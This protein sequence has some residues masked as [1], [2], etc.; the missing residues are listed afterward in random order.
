MPHTELL[1]S[2]LT[3]FTEKYIFPDKAATAAED[4]RA[5]MATGEFDDLDEETLS[6]R[7]TGLLD[8]HCGDKHLRLRPSEST[9]TRA[10]AASR[11]DV[12][13]SWNARCVRTNHGVHRVERLSGNVG[14]IDL[15]LITSPSVGAGA[16]A[17]AMNLV[18]NTNALIFDCR[19]NRG[20]DPLG[21]Q[22]WHS[23]LFPDADTHLNDIYSG[24][25]GR[26]RQYWTLAHVDGQRYTG[27]PVWVLTGDATFSAGEEFSY[28]L[29]ALER[30]TLVGETTRGGAHPTE[31]FP[32][33]P[34]MEVTIPI[35][36]S[37]NPVTGTNWEGTGVE[38][39]VAVPATEAFDTA[40]RAAL[41]HVS[42]LET[43]PAIHT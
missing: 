30:A 19:G 13:E 15:R 3:L 22:L 40:Y 5:R 39:D 4:V 24:D 21:V 20:G 37:I 17:A 43:H 35:A 34:T 9:S 29:K 6:Q 2:A 11:A 33:T 14:Y 12:E 32:L 26:T 27:K 42:G 41:E 16:I 10:G 18:A 25:T 31:V 36:R 1:E 28:N 38:P 23:Y 8:E 7:I